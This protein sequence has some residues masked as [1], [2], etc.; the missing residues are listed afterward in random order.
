MLR[1]LI[2]LISLLF[3]FYSFAQNVDS[4]NKVDSQLLLNQNQP[5]EKIFIKTENEAN[6]PG[7]DK[8][9]IKYL[10]KN[11]NPEFIKNHDEIVAEQ[12][13]TVRFIVNKT[14]EITSVEPFKS[15]NEIILNEAVRLL[16]S[17]PKWQ[18]A[19][20]NGRNVN[21]YRMKTF[22]FPIDTLESDLFYDVIDDPYHTPIFKGGKSKWQQFL[23]N[24]LDNFLP[25]K[26][27][28]PPGEYKV[29]LKFIINEEG[30]VTNVKALTNFGY[31]METEAKRFMLKSPNWFPAY[32]NGKFVKSYVTEE[33]VFIIN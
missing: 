26:F 12:K 21:S 3:T 15:D 23:S 27:G 10:N 2:S 30:K 4:L 17:G 25:Q 32:I 29:I 33:I 7:G 13:I 5:E 14:G 8:E 11:V 22:T 31:G 9:W 19:S 16:K 24:E 18:P 1:L 6:F 20:Q 28:A